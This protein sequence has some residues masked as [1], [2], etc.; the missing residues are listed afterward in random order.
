MLEDHKI[1]MM[2]MT[3]GVRLK[4]SEGRPQSIILESHTHRLYL[5]ITGSSPSP[6]AMRSSDDGGGANRRVDDA[7]GANALHVSRVATTTA[8]EAT[9]AV[10]KRMM[11]ETATRVQRSV[12]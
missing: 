10:T 1:M 12:D 8:T 4:E 9:T 2:S 5:F 3:T 7:D 6:S 11:G